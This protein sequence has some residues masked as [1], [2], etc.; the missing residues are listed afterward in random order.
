[1]NINDNNNIDEI[2]NSRLNEDDNN[3]N[4][5]EINNNEFFNFGVK[6]IVTG[7]SII[8]DGSEMDQTFLDLGSD[9][10]CPTPYCRRH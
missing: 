7:D 3:K 2:N 5:D 9:I 6:K 8:A 1:M 4:I 10:I